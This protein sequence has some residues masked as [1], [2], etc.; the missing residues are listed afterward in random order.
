MDISLF[1]EHHRAYIL[2]GVVRNNRNGIAVRLGGL[3][4]KMLRLFVRQSRP[5][6][7]LPA[8]ELVQRARSAFEDVPYELRIYA[9]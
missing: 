3:E 5:E 1:P 9:E 7:A 2:S 8:E 4:G 6:P